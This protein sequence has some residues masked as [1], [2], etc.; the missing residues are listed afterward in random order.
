MLSHFN[1]EIEAFAPRTLTSPVGMGEGMFTRLYQKSRDGIIS[2]VF[3]DC[4]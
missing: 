2:R 3:S 4:L 1:A